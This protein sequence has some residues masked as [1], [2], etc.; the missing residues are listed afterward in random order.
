MLYGE[1]NVNIEA[2]KL[3]SAT[4]KMD[5]FDCDE[6]DPNYKVLESQLLSFQN[7]IALLKPGD[8]WRSSQ[9]L[10]SPYF[11]E[12]LFKTNHNAIFLANYYECFVVPADLETK[13][14]IIYG[15]SESEQIG[16]VQLY[17]GRTRVGSI[18]IKSDLIWD[19]FYPYFVIETD[20]GTIHHTLSNHEE[21]LSLQ[22]WNVENKNEREIV[23]Y[24]NNILFKLAIEKGLAFK[25]VQPAELW[26]NRGIAKTYG[27]QVNSTR[28]E[29]IPLAYMNYAITCENP[30]V[31][32]L[33]FYQ[34]LEYFFV[35]A[36]NQ[37][38]IAEL[39]NSGILSSQKTN[40]IQLRGILKRYTNTLKE[41]ESLKLVLQ[42]IIDV[43][44]LK[45]YI[46]STPSKLYQY[47]NDVT[48]SDKIQIHLDASDIKIIHKLSDR[49]YFFRCAI[50]HAKG[51]IDEYLAL[52][53]ISDAIIADELP[54][55]KDISYRALQIWGKNENNE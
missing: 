19:V 21:F 44:K 12:C 10:I 4:L 5:Q 32:F 47:T 35:R 24:I 39:N 9:T 6:N 18:G 14:K 23:E 31:A 50:A 41:A 25:R 3:W 46:N 22:L 53:E 29:A 33:H 37:N 40:D 27:I 34:V 54:L 2:L 13:K 16:E 42:K 26:K 1:I 17:D 36:Q 28:L 30:R 11:M 51:D 38:V 43:Q 52:P 7:F 49:I 45:N 20:W 15:Y 8:D 48:I 55:L